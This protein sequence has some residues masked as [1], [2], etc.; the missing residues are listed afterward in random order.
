MRHSCWVWVEDADS[1]VAVCP[2]HG[3]KG[4]EFGVWQWQESRGWGELAEDDDDEDRGD[5]RDEFTKPCK[6]CTERS[7]SQ[8][9]TGQLVNGRRGDA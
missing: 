3:E 5:N 1:C 2:W 6:L 4:R 8:L 7:H 9:L